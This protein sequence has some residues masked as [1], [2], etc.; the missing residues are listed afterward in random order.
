MIVLSN[1]N[2]P[3]LLQLI[4][5]DNT[6][7]DSA[8][9]SYIIYDTNLS[10]IVSSQACDYS[11]TVKGYYDKLDVGVDW[12]S[13]A[14]G[15]YLLVWSIESTGSFPSVMTEE[16]RVIPGGIVEGIYSQ[17]DVNKILLAFAAGKSTGGGTGTITF[18]DQ[19]G[20]TD[21]ITAEVTKRGNR[22]NVTLDLS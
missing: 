20:T 12:S 17:T 13:Q 8:T 21:R 3:M 16:L 10:S 6:F 11:N 15:N 7:E 5:T 4:K 14:E 2:I 1:T 22:T 19:S 9:V 18:K